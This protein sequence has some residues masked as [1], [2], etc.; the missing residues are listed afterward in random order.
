[1][2]LLRLHHLLLFLVHVLTALLA[3]PLS[4]AAPVI[5]S[6]VGLQASGLQLSPDTQIHDSRLSESS[7][8]DND[9]ESEGLLSDESRPNQPEMPLVT[10]NDLDLY[11]KTE[12]LERLCDPRNLCEMRNVGLVNKEFFKFVRGQTAI[13]DEGVGCVRG[14]KPPPYR[15][16]EAIKQ[17]D[18]NNP[19]LVKAIK[20]SSRCAGCV[21]RLKDKM[22]STRKVMKQKSRAPG[23]CSC[24]LLLPE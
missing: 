3:I 22:G 16:I 24:L 11:T 9:E 19:T 1:M 21:A 5:P 15:L 13:C 18:F 23:S 10:F 8:L 14:D 7:D 17:M 20:G 2:A 6:N 12:I 4:A